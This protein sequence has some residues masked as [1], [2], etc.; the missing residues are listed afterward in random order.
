MTIVEEL[1][2][3]AD[4][5]N[6]AYSRDTITLTWE[7]RRRGHGRRRSDSGL[8]FA[9][10]LAN[11]TV[12]QGGDAFF[13]APEKTV[14]VVREAPEPVYVVRPRSPQEWAALAYHVGNRHQSLM[15]GE[16]ELILPR[17]PAVHSLLNQLR[18]AYSA[19][20]RPFTA[21]LIGSPH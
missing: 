18:A 4:R 17:N 11:G 1:A 8:E 20:S 9:I 5:D 7:D 15:I 14:V 12:L 6:P 19:D 21:S 2:P 13:L 10:S 3:S 16:E